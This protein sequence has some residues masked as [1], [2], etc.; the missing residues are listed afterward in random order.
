[1]YVFEVSISSLLLM[2]LSSNHFILCL[3]FFVLLFF[4][5][6]MFVYMDK[7]CPLSF[8]VFLHSF[9]SRSIVHTLPVFVALLLS[10]SL[11][12]SLFPLLYE[13]SL[14]LVCRATCEPTTY[15]ACVVL[16]VPLSTHKIYDKRG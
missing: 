3:F 9:A 4:F 11:S 10:L 16:C 7:C 14:L 12:L 13:Q 1:M 5:V 15:L 8:R 2:I 6:I